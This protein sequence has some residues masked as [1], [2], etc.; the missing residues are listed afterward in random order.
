MATRTKHEICFC[1]CVCVCV[2][3]VSYTHLD[4]YK[5]QTLVRQ[6]SM[7]LAMVSLT[8]G[9]LTLRLWVYRYDRLRHAVPWSDSFQLTWQWFRYR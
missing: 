6:L 9:R 5:R 2:C 4:V 1:V 8:I 3:A 7:N